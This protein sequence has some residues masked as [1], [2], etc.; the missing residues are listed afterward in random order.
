MLTQT[1]NVSL[2]HIRAETSK[3]A[4][5]AANNNNTT[6]T[7][8]RS[9]T[10]ALVPRQREVTSSEP[11]LFP[12]VS[13]ISPHQGNK[14]DAVVFLDS[15]S[16]KGKT[17]RRMS[18]HFV[19]KLLG[20]SPQSE[21]ILDDDEEEEQEESEEEEEDDDNDVPSSPPQ[22]TWSELDEE[23]EVACN[24]D[25]RDGQRRLLQAKR[26]AALRTI[27]PCL[28]CIVSLPPHHCTCSI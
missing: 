6:A 27:C 2:L 15:C 8:A 12:S 28:D 22:P 5:S 7:A 10:R 3:S 17:N 24:P 20:H 16:D 25:D 14:G 19:Q 23:G 1:F 4:L 9:Q 21:A 18:T 13:S 26:A 11:D